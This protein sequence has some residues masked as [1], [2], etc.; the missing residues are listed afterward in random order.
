MKNDE[1][2]WEAEP[3]SDPALP[4][5]VGG[6]ERLQPDAV[7]RDRPNVWGA[8][9]RPRGKLVAGDSANL[10]GVATVKRAFSEKQARVSAVAISMLGWLI[11]AASPNWLVDEMLPPK[12]FEPFLPLVSA[13]FAYGSDVVSVVPDLY[14]AA[15]IGLTSALVVEVAKMVLLR[16]GSRALGAYLS[17]CLLQAT[18]VIDVLRRFA[19]DWYGYLLH[20]F[21]LAKLSNEVRYPE[22]LLIPPPFLSLLCLMATSLYLLVL[23]R[24]RPPAA[25]RARP[26]APL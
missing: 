15:T 24:S 19:V 1:Y 26:E 25:E 9:R 2:P 6:W 3:H 20:F 17:F 22:P 8:R 5:A 16:L 7:P 14:S 13:P 4:G 18:L 23:L 12:R 21:R 11:A 10:H